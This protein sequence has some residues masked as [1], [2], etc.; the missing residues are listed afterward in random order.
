MTV[1]AALAL[2]W[3]LDRA[4]NDRGAAISP[5]RVS[6]TIQTMTGDFGSAA[7]HLPC[8]AAGVPLGS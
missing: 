4:F 2:I 6:I 5:A 3:T 1:F 8:D 7:A